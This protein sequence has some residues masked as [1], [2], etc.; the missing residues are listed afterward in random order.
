MRWATLPLRNSVADRM[1]RRGL[2]RGA[3]ILGLL[4]LWG[5]GLW[6]GP[7]RPLYAQDETQIVV[8]IAEFAP[9]AVIV[10]A[11]T[12]QTVEPAEVTVSQFTAIKDG[13]G[14]HYPVVDGPRHLAVQ[15]PGR[16]W[17]TSSWGDGIG[18]LTKIADPDSG[19]VRY[20]LEFYGFDQGSEPYDI[21]FRNNT[22]WFTLLRA[23]ALGRMNATTREVTFYTLPTPDSRPAG[24]D[25]APNGD[26]WIVAGNGRLVRFDP[27][28]ESFTEIL[29]SDEMAGAQRGITLRYQNERNIWFTLPDANAVGNSNTVTE[30]FLRIP[31]GEPLPTGLA[32]D[33]SGGVWVTVFG[34]G[35]VGRYT[36]TTVSVWV[37]YG[38]PSPA[39]KPA[40]LILFDVGDERQLWLTESATGKAGRLRLD[41]GTLRGRIGVPL[42]PAPSRPW[43]IARAGDGTL[44]IADMGRDRLIELKAPYIF[45]SHWPLLFR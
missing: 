17:F 14:I 5:S 11:A 45:V 28:T 29:Y 9:A 33:P 8:E 4:L 7:A 16:V 42:G 26:V 6:P 19:G 22:V 38:T 13:F 23:N 18:L 41:G 21:V 2:R 39:S 31:T 30:R 3:L 32:L 35:R 27:L 36:P 43:G 1:T 37:W 44:W 34:G 12:G 40:S 10:S 20:W 15:S 25:L 24:L